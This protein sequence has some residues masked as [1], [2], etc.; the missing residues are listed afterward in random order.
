MTEPQGALHWR[1]LLMATR[2]S[3][4]S[5][6]EWMRTCEPSLADG[7]RAHVLEVQKKR[8]SF[9]PTFGVTR[10]EDKDKGKDDAVLRVTTPPLEP[11]PILVEFKDKR[12]H[13]GDESKSD[14][15]KWAILYENQRGY[16][17]SPS[18]SSST[19]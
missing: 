7:A 4:P 17:V 13:K 9:L 5:P 3:G 19:Q 2:S 12:K 14:Q 16:V 10:T 11:E 1:P 6:P 18:P 8:S 15:F